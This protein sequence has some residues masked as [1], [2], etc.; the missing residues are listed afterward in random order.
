MNYIQGEKFYCVADQQYSPNIKPEFDDYNIIVNTFNIKNLCDINIIYTHT[1][2]I[3]HLF[4]EIKNLNNK[5]IIITHNSDINVDNTFQIPENVIKWFTQNV[6]VKN[7]KLESIPIGL[8]NNKWN[9]DINK[10]KNIIN[11]QKNIKNL[12]YINHKIKTNIKERQEPYKLFSNKNW[13]TLESNVNY[14]Q[15]I[16]N[17]YNYK[18]VLCPNG[19]GIDTHRL[20]ECLY[21][22][23][24][25]IVKNNINNSYYRDLQI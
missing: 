9:P 18:F 22:K 2:Y 12:L 25:P 20:W 14:D 7:D 13:A 10:I 6:N 4:K 16:N 17:V 23:T 1:L 3:K 21:V 8:P 5:F 15:Y 11:K 24:I 19:N